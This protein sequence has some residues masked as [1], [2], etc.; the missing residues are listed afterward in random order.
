[1]DISLTK[2]ADYLICSLYQD[3]KTRV[4]NGSPRDV[5][6]ICGSAQD[7]QRDVTPNL[8][9]EDITD[10][11]KELNRKELLDIL[12]SDC[13]LSKSMLTDR[14]IIYMENRFQNNLNSLLSTISK[15]RSYLP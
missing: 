8:S 9:T 15:L 10:F 13:E 11:A 1:M 4:K 2:D 7:I 14:A 5:A 6:K 12:V 3:Y